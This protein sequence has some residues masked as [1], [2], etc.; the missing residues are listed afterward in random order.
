MRCI[1]TQRWPRSGRGSNVATRAT[2]RR[3]RLTAVATYDGQ[4]SLVEL[5]E[6]FQRPRLRLTRK[7]DRDFNIHLKFTSRTNGCTEVAIGAGFEMDDRSSPLGDPSRSRAR[8]GDACAFI[9]GVSVIEKTRRQTAHGLIQDLLGCK[10]CIQ[11]VARATGPGMCLTRL[12]RWV[13]V[14]D[15]Q[16]SRRIWPEG[17]SRPRKRPNAAA[18]AT[19]RRVRLTAIA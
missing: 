7:T 13:W 16:R 3:L 1:W 11:R 15:A 4:M 8:L 2:G 12:Q 5:D 19:G 18:R 17:W 10:Q 9:D 14:R 6:R